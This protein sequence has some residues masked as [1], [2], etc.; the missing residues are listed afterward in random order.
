[1]I[2]FFFSF[3]W[4]TSSMIKIS[5]GARE[6]QKSLSHVL[7]LKADDKIKSS[8]SAPVSLSEA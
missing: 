4:I 6:Q 1:M 7:Q 3:H 5:S 2:L 8:F